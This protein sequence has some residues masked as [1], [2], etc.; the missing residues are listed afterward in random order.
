MFRVGFPE[1]L[2]ILLII[3]ILFGAS[4]LPEVAKALGNAIKEFK[5][6]IREN[7]E[8]KEEKN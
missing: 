6:A 2:F 7:Q 4:K 3:L 1:L 8:D 5:K